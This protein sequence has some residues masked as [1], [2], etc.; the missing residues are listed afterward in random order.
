MPVTGLACATASLKSKGLVAER[1]AINKRVRDNTFAFL[2]KKNI[3]YIPSETNFF[4]MEVNRPGTEFAQAM[5]AQKVIIGR[6]WP[7][8]PTK[9]RVT[10][11]TQ[12]EMDKFTAAVATIVG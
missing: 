4:M 1:R 6:V 12:A 2:E 10:V 5:A 11:G 3:K 8:W 9:V 7:A